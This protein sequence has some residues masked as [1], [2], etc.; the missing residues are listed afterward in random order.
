MKTE[1]KKGKTP[2]VAGH[3]LY[4]EQNSVF[5]YPQLVTLVRYWAN[6]KSYLYEE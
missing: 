1:L 6:E 5:L 3:Y 4:K 2:K